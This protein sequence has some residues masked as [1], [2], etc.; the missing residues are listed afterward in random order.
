MLWRFF[1]WTVSPA[2]VISAG[3]EEYPRP[4]FIEGIV[5]RSKGIQWTMKEMGCG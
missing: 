4:A 5:A 2:S 3:R 1:S